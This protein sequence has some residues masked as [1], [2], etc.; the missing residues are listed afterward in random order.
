MKKYIFLVILIILVVI[1]CAVR[2]GYRQYDPLPSWNDRNAKSDIISFVNKV[3]DP[4]NQDFILPADRIVTF[5]F[6]GTIFCEKPNYAN[7]MVSISHYREAV[8]QDSSLKNIQPYKAALENDFNYMNKHMVEFLTLDHLD[9][10]EEDYIASVSACMDTTI[11]A[12]LNI[13]YKYLFYIP[14]VELIEYLLKEDFQ[15]F[16]SSGSMTGFLR[17][18]CKERLPLEPSHIIGSRVELVYSF[19]DSTT[20]FLRKEKIIHNNNADGKALGI[21]SHIGK[22]PIIAVGNSWGDVQ[23]LR[24]AQSNNLQHLILIVNHDDSKREYE[25]YD[26]K[27]LELCK[28]NGWIIISM[29]KDFKNIFI[30]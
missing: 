29:K 6:D 14:M 2:K 3:T 8:K 22:H 10:T 18:A 20:A 4:S 30:E 25:Y 24:Y 28:Q 21:Y 17:G 13:P 19:E 23:M 9:K 16:I 1:S 15:V 27:L 26:K 12:H 7:F 11:N 5:D